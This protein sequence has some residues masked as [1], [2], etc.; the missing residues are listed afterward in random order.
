MKKQKQTYVRCRVFPPYTSIKASSTRK[1]LPQNCYSYTWY[2]VR[3]ARLKGHLWSRGNLKNQDIKTKHQTPHPLSPVQRLPSV[4]RRWTWEGRRHLP[5]KR[6]QCPRGSLR[7]PGPCEPEAVKAVTRRVV[8]PR[9]LCTIRGNTFR[10]NYSS[11]DWLLVTVSD[12]LW[13]FVT[14]SDC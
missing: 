7:E 4:A 5:P 6:P 9:V 11:S 10:P 12:Y 13:L 1:D 8:K 14:I 2:I 3:R